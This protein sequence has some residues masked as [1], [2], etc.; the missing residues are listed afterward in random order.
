MKKYR[1]VSVPSSV[2]GLETGIFEKNYLFAAYITLLV[3]VIFRFITL[4]I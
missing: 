4:P 1:R 3:F 2:V